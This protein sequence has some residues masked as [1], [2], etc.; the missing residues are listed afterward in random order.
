MYFILTLFFFF[1]T[2]SK[3]ILILLYLFFLKKVIANNLFV[4]RFQLK[5][6]MQPLRPYERHDTLKQFLDHDRKVLRF[7]CFWDDSQSIY[8]DLRELILH[9]F[10]VDDTIEIREVIPPNSGRDKVNKFLRRC[11]LPKVGKAA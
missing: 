4:S 9:Y 8:V 1:L 10:L 3:Y 2:L 11:R 6:S 7:Y 5:K